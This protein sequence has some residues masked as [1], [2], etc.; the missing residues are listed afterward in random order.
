M[1]LNKL[2]AA[3][4]SLSFVAGATTNLTNYAPNYSVKAN[5]EGETAVV[6]T[7]AVTITK[8]VS[9]TT[10]KAT[11]TTTVATTPKVVTTQANATTKV[12]TATT[13]NVATTLKAPVTSSFVTVTS[14]TKPTTT[15]ITLAT[16]TSVVTSV[17]TIPTTTSAN[18]TG[19]DLGDVNNDGQIN[20]VDASSV[21]AYYAKLSTNQN[22]GYDESQKLAADVNHD[23][24][25]NAVDASG[26]LSYYAYV[27]TSNGELKTLDEFLKNGI[28]VK[29]PQTFV[30]KAENPESAITEVQVSLDCTGDVKETMKVESIMGKDMMG[31]EVV[32]LVGEPFL[33]ETSSEF[34][35]ATITYK[36]DK[37][38]LGDT[39]FND[40]MFLWYD[41]ENDNFVELETAHD[42]TNSTVSTVTTHFSDYM[43]TDGKAWLKNW[44]D[45]ANKLKPFYEKQINTKPAYPVLSYTDGFQYPCFMENGEENIKL[46]QE[47]YNWSDSFAKEELNRAKNSST[48]PTETS[49]WPFLITSSDYQITEE[50]KKFS[51]Y[52]NVCWISLTSPTNIP[53]CTD[54]TVNPPSERPTYTDSETM[55]MINNN[56]SNRK[57]D[58]PYCILDYREGY[59]ERAALIAE[60]TGGIYVKNTKEG[61]DKLKSFIYDPKYL[62]NP[63]ELNDTDGDGF[64]DDVVKNG[65]LYQSNGKPAPNHAQ[66]NAQIALTKLGQYMQTFGTELPQKYYFKDLKKVDSDKDG[67]S[68]Y[69]D[70]EPD[71]FNIPGTVYNR[72][73]VVEYAYEHY[74]IDNEFHE[75]NECTSFA[76][77][78]LEAG[79]FKRNNNW[80]LYYDDSS[81]KEKI[82][83][84][85]KIALLSKGFDYRYDVNVKDE[86]TGW[87][88]TKS[89]HEASNLL[90]WVKSDDC[91]CKTMENDIYKDSF[92]KDIEKLFEKG[93]IKEGDLLFF[94]N[95]E[96]ID[97][98]MC[99]NHTA[100]VTKIDSC[101]KK[102]YYSQHTD[103]KK[104]ALFTESKND[105]KVIV[106]HFL[107]EIKQKL[108]KQTV[109]SFI[110]EY[111][112]VHEYELDEL[113]KAVCDEYGKEY[114]DSLLSF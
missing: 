5:A 43:V 83:I 53:I 60:K 41:R 29:L 42:E 108:F 77:L 66:L 49:F 40:L 61:I 68:D 97:E 4:L 88:Y 112:K 55:E 59:D 93:E 87:I 16:S 107:P 25:I 76:S 8:A 34:D 104:D 74:N 73:A 7:T 95:K 20:A 98:G 75:P 94:C 100:V 1:N 38:K 91:L 85:D 6:T 89:W 11:V 106:I 102:I 82:S 21:L 27:S 22:G 111:A 70:D 99:P 78:C 109:I 9:T 32:G 96:E 79:G 17:T 47:I 86:P 80:D 51:K 81:D 14:T 56:L 33:I 48:R 15:A 57:N 35:K 63:S 36:V 23:G 90:N 50:K 31:S 62:Y 28:S 101:N 92:S 39:D 45:I 37:S 84:P 67:I 69:Y 3:V 114:V 105:Y 30:H 26:I 19:Y 46:H 24:L 72:Q 110:C 44:E 71:T 10:T 58:T 113:Y 65:Y 103:S 12:T 54:Y 13:T 18:T 52:I 2:I 64:I